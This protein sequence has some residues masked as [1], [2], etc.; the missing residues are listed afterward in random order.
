MVAGNWKMHKTAGEGAILT[1]NIE[2]LVS[3]FW[4]DVDVVVCP[5]FTALKS[6]STVIELDKLTMGLGAQDVYWEPDGAFTGAISTRMLVDLRCDYVIVGHSERREY[7]GETD[8]SVNKKVRAVFL[9]GMVPIVC[10]GES[11]AT[12]E[13]GDTDAHVRAQV[14]AALAGVSAE[15]AARVIIAYEPIWAIG[16]GRT[17]T[18]E[19][20][21]DVSRSIRATVGA[22]FG[23]PAA[24]SAR[25]LYGGSV[26]PENASMFFTE[27]DIDGALVGGAALDAG[28]FAA[29][30]EAAR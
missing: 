13:A 6:V 16:T 9:A 18:P 19:S 25:V 20:A 14:R 5:P 24:L 26:K 30:A 29:I 17:P 12:R 2:S 10:V 23:Q 28:S 21:N 7:F 27:P 11:L 1:Q 15:E 3:G 8:E 4:D 22:L